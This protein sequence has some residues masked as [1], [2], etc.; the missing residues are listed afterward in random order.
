MRSV[1]ICHNNDLLDREG[2]ARWLASFS[3]LAG[4]VVLAETRARLWRRIRRE[5][6]RVGV[7]R[8]AD[9]LA[10]RLY[11]R[12]FL[13][14]RDRR[15]ETQALD[16]LCRHFPPLPAATR[17]LHAHSPNTPE[18]ERFL[19][20]LAPT[21]MVARCKALLKESIF[22]I[23]QGGTFVLHPGVC[24]QYRNAHGCFWALAQDD[25]EHVGLTLLKIDKGIDTGPV[26]G[27]FCP[28]LDE[29]DSHFVIQHRAL[30]DNLDA[31][32]DRLLEAV[33]GR[34]TPLDTAGLPSREWGQPWLT[35][36]WGWQRRARRRRTHAAGAV[37]P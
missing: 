25:L 19:R 16:G 1:L 14:H 30:F 8:F 2:V 12:L 7:L 10:F 4:V 23:P 13:R 18:V 5:V 32:R 37:V 26:Y 20:E 29:G 34:A 22:S 24:P 17:I 36:Y 31:V 11:H 28:E 6:R 27:Y 33:A 35:A 3:D 21:F 15:W 9:V